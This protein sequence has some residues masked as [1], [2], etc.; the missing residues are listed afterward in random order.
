MEAQGGKVP[1]T[2]SADSEKSRPHRLSWAAGSGSGV[3][4]AQNL[5][6]LLGIYCFL[7][8]IAGICFSQFRELPLGTAIQFKVQEWQSIASHNSK[9][10]KL[11]SVSH[12]TKLNWSSLR[13]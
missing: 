8:F 5:G 9:K 6:L 13:T 1:P 12:P 3:L 2:E 10:I 11:N 7:E 4:S